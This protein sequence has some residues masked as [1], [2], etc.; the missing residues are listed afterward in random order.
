MLF[1]K[2]FSRK[3]KIKGKTVYDF[4]A[5]EV[6]EISDIRHD[7][8]TESYEI[9]SRYTQLKLTF[10]KDQ[11]FIDETGGVYLLPVWSLHIR[12][13][14]RKLLNLRNSFLEMKVLAHAIEPEAFSEQLKSMM[15]AGIPYGEDVIKHL[16][17]FEEL[18]IRL[19]KGKQK[20]I[21]ETTH[22]MTRRLLE[23]GS[24]N[25]AQSSSILTKKE[26]SLRIIEL[27]RKF[28]EL[29]RLI[30][31]ISELYTKA[32]SC[33][34]FLEELSESTSESEPKE[35]QELIGRADGLRIK[36]SEIILI[37]DSLVETPA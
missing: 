36:G 10:P 4:Q 11:F 27:R 29:S 22:L 14:C 28:G 18:L 3:K 34:E 35:V 31:F 25:H 26:Y 33:L 17:K 7:E 16:P 20:I 21:D 32:K 19:S 23:A 24:K 6:G 12:V 15:K 9:L 30:H 13:S 1:H 37:L 5:Q 2:W 8:E